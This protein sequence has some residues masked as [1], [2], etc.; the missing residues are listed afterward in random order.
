M[1]CA[2]GGL[3]LNGE[4]CPYREHAPLAS[5][6]HQAWEVFTASLGQL[7]IAPSG[8]VLGIDMTAALGIAR[9][10]GFDEGV[11]SELL[12]SAEAGLIEAMNE[13]S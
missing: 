12:Q 11:I 1:P 13:K 8:R 4:P 2:Q 10:R 7:R 6:E 3:G 5:E 9:A